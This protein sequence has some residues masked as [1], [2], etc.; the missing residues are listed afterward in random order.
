M[1]ANSSDGDDDADRL[2]HDDSKPQSWSKSA[3]KGAG[4]AK[5]AAASGSGAN[6]APLARGSACVVCRKRKLRCDGIRPACTTCKRLNHDCRYGDPLHE[7]LMETNKELEDRIRQLEDELELARNPART[8]SSASGPSTAGFP[9]LTIPHDTPAPLDN[10]RLFIQTQFDQPPRSSESSLYSNPPSAVSNAHPALSAQSHPSSLPFSSPNPSSNPR[11]NANLYP[12]TSPDSHL[13]PYAHPPTGD[14]GRAFPFEDNEPPS[15]SNAPIVPGSNPFWEASLLP[16]I[17]H[18]HQYPSH[19]YAGPQ[20]PAH[21]SQEL[22]GVWGGDLPDIELTV[23]LAKWWYERAKLRVEAVINAG[24]N[25]NG[26]SR[27]NLTVEIVQALCLLLQMEMGAS[28]HQKAFMTM[29]SAARVSEMLGLHRMD[30]DRIAC[31]VLA[32]DRF[33]SGCNGWPL[34]I[35]EADVRLLLPCEDALY[36]S[37]KCEAEDCPLWWPILPTTLETED[38]KLGSFAWLC[39]SFWL[40]GRIQQENYRP[41]GLLADGPFRTQELV[42]P[43]QNMDKFL[44]MDRDLHIIRAKLNALATT[45]AGRSFSAPTIMNL[46]LINCLF[47]NLHHLRVSHGLT[48]FPFNPSAPVSIGTPEYS[49]QRCLEGA[50]SLAEILSQLAMYE[51]ARTSPHQSRVNTF[52][53]FSP[54]MLYC[55]GLPA[56]F[57]IGDWVMMTDD[58]SRTE[59][60]P[61]RIVSGDPQVPNGDD[62]F[63]QLLDESR[64]NL[65]DTFCDAMDRMGLVWPIGIKFSTLVQNDKSRLAARVAARASERYAS[66]APRYP[67]TGAGS[68]HS[69]NSPT[70]GDPN[71]GYH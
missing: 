45:D 44:A 62:I 53:T 35:S 28:E 4:G 65:I 61:S 20:T 64:L 71:R 8:S 69:P 48:R 12:L 36:E 54:Y 5:A 7:K 68:L 37:G 22:I 15:T 14:F 39:R 19:Q 30:E 42:S 47:I 38:V 27:A 46:I 24:I 40:G 17:H 32:L 3:K 18:P 57:C 26:Q 59:Q 11:D 66:S 9:S 16:P 70:V 56:K 58:R 1:K 31:T 23:E 2:D 43:M 29:G 50:S 52:T 41:S 60:I 51:N 33:E 25:E 34:A 21:T 55:I 13:N 6:K 63:G 10:T 67:P 49:M